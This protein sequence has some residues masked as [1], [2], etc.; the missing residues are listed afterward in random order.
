MIFFLCGGDDDVRNNNVKDVGQIHQEIYYRKKT[1]KMVRKNK[2]WNTDGK[3]AFER[4][5]VLIFHPS[6]HRKA[7]E[8]HHMGASIATFLIK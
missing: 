3:P 5:E 4:K 6:Y 8:K 2:I 7:G 1:T